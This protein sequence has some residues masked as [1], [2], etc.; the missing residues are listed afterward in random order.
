MANLVLMAGVFVF[1]FIIGY[2]LISQR[3]STFTHAFDVHDQC[4]F[5]G[6]DTGCPD[7]VFTCHLKALKNF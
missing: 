7:P 3:S 1:S 5:R 2:A 6:Y 4:H